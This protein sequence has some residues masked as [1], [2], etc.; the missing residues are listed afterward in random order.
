MGGSAAALFEQVKARRGAGKAIIALARKFLEIICRTLKNEW[1]LEDFRTLCSWRSHEDAR[2]PAPS[3]MPPPP[4]HK[5]KIS[6]AV[7]KAGYYGR[8]I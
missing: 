1:V 5:V 8:S 2:E 4:T 7:E 6:R 3:P